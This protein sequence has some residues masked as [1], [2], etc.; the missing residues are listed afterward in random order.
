MELVNASAIFEI[1]ISSSTLFPSRHSKSI[2][3][4]MFYTPPC[5]AVVSWKELLL[6][7]S[8]QLFLS[9]RTAVEPFS[10]SCFNS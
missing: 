3:T 5:P 8:H 4:K 2:Y 1:V 6:P 7:V 9:A 10:A